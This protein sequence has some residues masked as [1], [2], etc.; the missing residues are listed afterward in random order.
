[1]PRDTH[2]YIVRSIASGALE[3]SSWGIPAAD[4][5]NVARRRAFTISAVSANALLVG[6]DKLAVGPVG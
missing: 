3:D 4:T 2:Q 6:I 5:R 1:M